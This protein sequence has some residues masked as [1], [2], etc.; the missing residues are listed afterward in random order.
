MPLTLQGLHVDG[1]GLDLCSEASF[2]TCALNGAETFDI[3]GLM[4]CGAVAHGCYVVALDN[5][6]CCVDCYFGRSAAEGGRCWILDMD[7]TAGDVATV[8]PGSGLEAL[9]L[10]KGRMLPVGW[11]GDAPGSIRYATLP[12]NLICH[13]ASWCDVIGSYLVVVCWTAAGIC[14]GG[15]TMLCVVISDAI[16]R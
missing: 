10:V 13:G 5:S 15:C 2:W 3:A 7:F 4:E 16:S 12:G 9:N 14:C 8:Q 6:G 1:V 11:C